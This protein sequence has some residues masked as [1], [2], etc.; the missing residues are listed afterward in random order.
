MVTF[1]NDFLCI[2][3]NS[4]KIVSSRA[5]MVQWIACWYST[6]KVKGSIPK[7]GNFYT[8]VKLRSSNNNYLTDTIKDE[9]N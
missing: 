3:I 9:L 7:S 5:S 6:L 1:Y 4:F 8:F 2:K